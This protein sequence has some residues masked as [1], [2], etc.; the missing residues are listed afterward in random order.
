MKL[1]SIFQKKIDRSIKGVIKTG[2]KDEENI[3]QELEEFVITD[4]IK[5]HMNKIFKEYAL[6]VSG[7]T[8]NNGIWISGFFG[9][10]KSHFLKVLSYILKGNKV[11][12]KNVVSYFRGK[13]L[14]KATLDNIKKAEEVSSD[15]ILFNIASKIQQS[16]EESLVSVFNRAFNEVR[17]LC[18]SKPWIAAIEEKLIDEGIYEEFKNSFSKISSKSW[19]EG[20]EN[21]HFEKDFI[22]EALVKVANINEDTALKWCERSEVEFTLTVEEFAKRL[23][24]YCEARGNNHHV[25]FLVDEIGQYMGKDTKL[26]LNLQ[27]IVEELAVK[28][29]GKCWVVVTAQEEIDS[30]IDNESKD[31]SKILGRF[32]TRILLSSSNADEVIKQRVLKK[33]K[34]SES[35]LK[36]YYKENEANIKN[37]LMFSK[38]SGLKAYKGVNDFIETYPF[39]SCEFNMLQE[40]LNGIR[41]NSSAGKDISRGERSLLELYQNAAKGVMS[42]EIG[43]II[44]FYVFY[45]EIKEYLPYSIKDVIEE[46]EKD[47]EIEGSPLQ[48]LKTLSLLRYLK[49]L[50]GDIENILTLNI[51]NFKESKKKIK[52]KID[53][54]LELLINYGLIEKRGTEYVFLTK[55]EQLINR[56]IDAILIKKEEVNQKIGEIIFHEI[57]KNIKFNYSSQYKFYFNRYVDNLLIGSGRSE[58]GVR[59]ITSDFEIEGD[60]IS[61]L[62]RLSEGKKEVIVDI[63]DSFN[64]VEAVEDLLKVDCYMRKNPNKASTKIIQDINIKKI[65]ERDSIAI[66]TIEYLRQS[67]RNSKIYVSGIQ[68]HIGEKNG[69]HKIDE[70]LLYLINIEYFKLG[71]IKTFRDDIYELKEVAS[72]E[73]LDEAYSAGELALEEVRAFIEGDVSRGSEVSL[74][75]ILDRFTQIPYGWKK[76]DIQGVIL[77]LI[78]NDAIKPWLKNSYSNENKEQIKEH[79]INKIEVNDIFFKPSVKINPKYIEV[80]REVAKELFNITININDSEK[81]MHKFKA[82][83]NG[84]VNDINHMLYEL[85]GNKGYPGKDVLELGVEL[86][87]DTLNNDEESKFYREVYAMK[88]E[89]EEYI[90]EI[91]EV[92]DFYFKK[93]DGK[94]NVLQKGEQRIIFDKAS[95]LLDEYKEQELFVEDKQITE[96]MN[97]VEDILSNKKPYSYI[98]NLP[99]LMKAYEQ[100]ITPL[101]EIEKNR[102][103]EVLKESR[104][105]IIFLADNDKEIIKEA[106]IKD[107]EEVYLK[108]SAEKNLMRLAALEKLVE[109]KKHFYKNTIK[110]NL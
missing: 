27:T 100:E 105:E 99:E 62:K 89:F 75:L 21:F 28:C 10:G 3:K 35:Y 74:K 82:L 7:A 24:K 77:E 14:S 46:A 69:V 29:E 34:K 53:N 65:R 1:K 37:L 15:V 63:S 48:I 97:R 80:I 45:D 59:I 47:L 84:E 71:Y 73:N 32:N 110:E 67:L 17:G 6:S 61:E 13:G 20:R 12:G 2:H 23:N 83:C 5:F 70:G 16:E 9:S 25:V 38:E 68:L 90:N 64:V 103:L 91:Q 96:V 49:N 85:K 108:I 40:I 101:I 4:E 42:K 19:D 31:F 51:S 22:I 92:K 58:I 109:R 41:E 43:D 33:N 39:I 52:D 56:E 50:N 104:D 66:E 95:R 87:N 55:E 107:F 44:P 94:I 78:N 86:F 54:S 102:I 76:I 30:F 26:M 93:S 72:A 36:D 79:I 81:I 106:V 88:D 8:D 11:D 18:G 98:R 60:K 57:Y